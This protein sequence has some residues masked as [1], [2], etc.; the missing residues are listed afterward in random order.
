LPS[1]IVI[2]DLLKRFSSDQETAIVFAY[3][4]YTDQCSVTDILASFVKQLVQ[5]HPSVVVP[6]IEPVY[7]DHQRKETRLS[8]RELQELVQRLL[9]SFKKTYIIIDALDELPDNT[10]SNLPMVLSLR[11][12][13][14]TLLVTSRPLQLHLP[15][16]YV[17]VEVKSQTDIELFIDKQIEETHCLKDLLN[18]NQ[19]ATEEIRASLKQKSQGMCVSYFGLIYLY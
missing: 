3:C 17:R 18:G 15:D 1:S 12:S 19:K 9:K 7:K 4:R 13:R 5:D 16:T 6:I 11:A 8:E 10:R 14:A 2:H